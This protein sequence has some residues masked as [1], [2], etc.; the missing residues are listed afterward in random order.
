MLKR[1]TIFVIGLLGSFCAILSTFYSVYPNLVIVSGFGFISMIIGYWISKRIPGIT[2]FQ[3]SVSFGIGSGIML[4]SAFL[5]IVPKAVGFNSSYIAS[6]GGSGIAL[7]FI[8][9]YVMHELGHIYSHIESRFDIL[10]SISV[11]EITLHSVLAGAL[12]GVT[13]SNIPTLGLLF[14][15]GILFH[16]LPAGLMLGLSESNENSYLFILLPATAVGFAGLGTALVF[17]T[18]VAPLHRAFII[19]L[20]AG[21]FIHVSVDMI[22][23]C[24]GGGENS[25]HTHSHGTIVCSTDT[26]KYR[27]ISAIS[28][29]TGSIV[30]GA[31]W[32]L[33]QNIH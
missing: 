13:Y 11:L 5:I 6:V 27:F 12:L 25:E 28:V 26:D 2:L 7:G 31:I 4:M 16:K 22:P 9:G 8:S 17:P 3:K 23:E 32:V 20:S 10:H 33:L 14:G 29:A 30:L 15:F 18:T 19:G 21:F 24:V 1:E